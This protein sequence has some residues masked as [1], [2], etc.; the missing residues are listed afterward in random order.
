MVFYLFCEGWVSKLKN[1]APYS[2]AGLS[3]NFIM[4]LLA[5]DIPLHLFSKVKIKAVKEESV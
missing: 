1:P 3:K 4:L 2:E 5:Y